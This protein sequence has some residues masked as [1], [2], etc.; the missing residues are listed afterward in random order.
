MN[1]MEKDLNCP[2][3]GSI[4]DAPVILNC[5]HSFCKDCLQQS[6]DREGSTECPVCRVK[7]TQSEPIANLILNKLCEALKKTASSAS[8]GPEV[9]CDSHG[10]KLTLF[11]V[12]DD[13]LM[14]LVCRD[15][16]IHA[17]HKFHPICDV[18]SDYKVRF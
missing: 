8:A 14:C 6:W 13:Q 7:S 5:T 16:K 2:V 11:C 9:L 15:A 1:E 3:C 12:D 4:F 17:D 10:E 18:A